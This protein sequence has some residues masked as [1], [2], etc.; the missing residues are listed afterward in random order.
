[1]SAPGFSPRHGSLSAFYGQSGRITRG[2]VVVAGAALVG[3]VI[4]GLSVLSI[5]AAISPPPRHDA[6]AAPMVVGDP[7]IVRT[8]PP[9]P[10]KSPA[11]SVPAG[12]STPAAAIAPA[13]SQPA[14]TRPVQSPAPV[15]VQTMPPAQAQSVPLAVETKKKKT[16]ATSTRRRQRPDDDVADSSQRN[17]RPLYDSRRPFGSD[18]PYR[19]FDDNG[20][21]PY[22][23]GG[24]FFDFRGNDRWRY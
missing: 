4:G 14:P 7:R 21:R 24:N 15:E 12:A 5:V 3:L 23:N 1:M 13:A 22:N 2:V 20:G 11:A 10:A 6:P 17:A 18:G 9:A 19:S 16:R 8:L